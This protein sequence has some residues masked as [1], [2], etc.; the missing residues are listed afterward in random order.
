[1]L[2]G[3]RDRGGF[4]PEVRDICEGCK[5]KPAEEHNCSRVINLGSSLKFPKRACNCNDCEK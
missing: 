4:V 1:M 3:T 5:D 2:V